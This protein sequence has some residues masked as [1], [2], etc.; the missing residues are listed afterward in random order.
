[1]TQLYLD[2]AIFKKK[3]K[4]QTESPWT[5]T[6]ALRIESPLSLVCKA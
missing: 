5:L 1:M 4:K 2:T 3:N 6:A